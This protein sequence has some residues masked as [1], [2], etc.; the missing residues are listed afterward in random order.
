MEMDIPVSAIKCTDE[1][2]LTLN[3]DKRAI[4]ALPAVPVR[5]ATGS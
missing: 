1:D 5:R 3:L 2:G 4:A